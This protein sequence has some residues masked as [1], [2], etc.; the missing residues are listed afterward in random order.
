MTNAGAAGSLSESASERIGTG[1]S[2]FQPVDNV[3]GLVDDLVSNYPP[4]ATDASAFLGAQ[5]D[6]GLAWVHFPKGEGGLGGSPIDQQ[7]VLGRLAEAG[8]P[9]AEGRNVLGFGM[10]APTIMA[11][12][13]REQKQRFLR[14]LFTGEEVWCQLFSEPGAGSDLAALSTR[15]QRDGDG[16]IVNGQKVWTSL[17]HEAAF[18]LLIARTDPEAPKHKGMTAFAV[19]MR[20]EGVEVRPLYQATGE[21]EFNECFF[22]DVRIPDSQRVGDVGGGWSVAITTLMNERVSIGE[23]VPGRDAG[24]IGNALSIWRERWAGRS[25][26]HA[27]SMRSELLQSWVRNEVGRLTNLRASGLRQKGTPGPEG[28]VAKLFFAEENQRTSE[29]CVDLLGAE[30]ML[31]NTNRPDAK[32]AD[33][34]CRAFLRARGNSIEGGTSEIL[35]N[36]IGERVLGLPGEPRSD[37]DVPWKDVPRS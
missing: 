27:I 24:H 11:H 28:S 19:D 4:S 25:D 18:G 16:W 26:A 14:P 29:L 23:A 9:S 36:I 2:P 12:G 3:F 8:A 6:L 17:A 7:R 22:V 21:A 5:F 1:G 37:R 30:G 13:T 35:R 10:V 31:A 33:D 32:R 15:A 34:V 20:A